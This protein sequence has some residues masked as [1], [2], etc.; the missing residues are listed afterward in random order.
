NKVLKEIGADQI[1]QILVYNKI[2]VL[3]QEVTLDKD[4]N[5]HIYKVHVSATEKLGLD[6]LRLAITEF[7]QRIGKYVK[8]NE[9]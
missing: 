2:D 3:G 5:G 9:Y 7:G 1:P 8:Y 4:E 6:E